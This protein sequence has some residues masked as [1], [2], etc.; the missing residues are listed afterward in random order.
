MIRRD[1]IFLQHDNAPA[2]TSRVVKRKIEE[3]DGVETLSHPPYS[4]DLAPCDYHL[5]RSM[6]HFLRGRRFNNVAELE[7][8]IREFFASKD[9][10]FYQQGIEQLADCWLNVIEA[11]GLYLEE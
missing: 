6:A 8:G 5:F 2:H 4:P 7:N 9:R 1:Q 3:L 11:D 10:E